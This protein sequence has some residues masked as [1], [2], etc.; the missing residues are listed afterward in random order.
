MFFYVPADFL[1][2][3]T[4][5]LKYDIILLLNMNFSSSVF[6]YLFTFIL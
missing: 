2:Y 1:R 3:D 4:N 6:T 5:D